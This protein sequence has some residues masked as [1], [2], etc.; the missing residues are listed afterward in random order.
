M[1]NLKRMLFLVAALLLLSGCPWWGHDGD[2]GGHHEDHH[3][4]R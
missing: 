3:D 2:R 1:M 4:G